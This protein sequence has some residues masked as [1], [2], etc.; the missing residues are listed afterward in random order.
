MKHTQLIFFVL[1]LVYLF[2]EAFIRNSYTFRKKTLK[3]NFKALI[4]TLTYD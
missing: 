1:N 4:L 2:L 3:K